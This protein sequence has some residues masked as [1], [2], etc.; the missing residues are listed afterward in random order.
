MDNIRD[1]ILTT[2]VEDA[3][4]ENALVPKR[5]IDVEYSIVFASGP[6]FAVRRKT[7]ASSKVLVFLVSQSQYYIKDEKKGTIDSFTAVGY[8]KF[9]SDAP[10]TITLSEADGSECSWLRELERGKGYG[11]MLDGIIRRFNRDPDTRSAAM[12]NWLLYTPYCYHGVRSLRECIA[13]PE[14]IIKKVLTVCGEFQSADEIKR[15]FSQ[16][17]LN[18]ERNADKL[19]SALNS[20]LA[21]YS[22]GYY[23]AQEPI[24]RPHCVAEILVDA[25]GLSGLEEILREYFQ[26]GVEVFPSFESFLR[27]FYTCEF[28]SPRFGGT[29]NLCGA[30]KR[31][32]NLKDFKHY[33]WYQSVYQGYAADINNFMISWSDS[34]RMQEIIY[35][36]ITEK[37]PEHLASCEKKL[38]YKFSQIKMQI[39]EKKWN[40]MVEAMQTLEYKGKTYSIICPKTAADVLD[41]AQQQSNCVASYVG[42]IIHGECMIF[43]CRYTA[44][45]DKSLV[46]V[47]LRAD[48][49]LGQVKARFN[50][51]PDADAAEFVETWYE[52]VVLKSELWQQAA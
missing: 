6:D 28:H 44:V 50:H 1:F 8:A 30:E 13:A 22:F 4:T 52:K 25:Y 33:L 41:E 19:G 48:G 7:K 27:L 51:A 11:D 17:A 47:E 23:A 49:S 39:D 40:A 5:P 21:K 38:A 34:L 18:G 37:Y 14:Q 36:K 15:A 2:S 16:L 42:S 26:V 45:P 3:N 24:A 9:M 46:T 12:H 43:F 32:F 29:L 20:L 35:G 31:I 10:D